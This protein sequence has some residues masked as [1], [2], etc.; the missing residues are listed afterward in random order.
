[1]QDIDYK[2]VLFDTEDAIINDEFQGFKQDYLILHSLIRRHE[3]KTL[4]EIG[5]NMG[6]G[7]NIICNAMGNKFALNEKDFAQGNNIYSLDLPTELAHTSLQHPISEGKGDNV[8]SRCRF[9]FTQL[10]GDAMTFDFAKYSCEGY[11]CDGEHEYKN[12]FHETV[13]MLKTDPKLIIWHDADLKWVFDGIV[14]GTTRYSVLYGELF[15][16]TIPYNF[17]RVKGTRIA[18]CLRK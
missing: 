2:D 14:A 6:T 18:Y 17:F 13:E 5:T 8:G 11:F 3:P 12:V 4:F 16:K 10:L 15:N 7:T 9:P 1:M